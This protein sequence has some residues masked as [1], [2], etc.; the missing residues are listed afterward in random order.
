MM[1]SG[2]KLSAIFCAAG[3]FYLPV[4]S[5]DEMIVLPYGAALQS[6]I[7]SHPA[8]SDYELETGVHRGHELVLKAGDSLSGQPGAVLSGAELLV[9]WRFEDPFWIHDGPHSKAVPD[10]DP[11]AHYWEFRARWPH[12]LFVD[13]VP[14]IQKYQPAQ[15]NDETSWAYDYE[16]DR[17]YVRFDPAQ[18]KM[19]L[20]GLCR[21]G[22]RTDAPDVELRNIHCTKF[23]TVGQSAAV[24]LGEHA[25]I[26]GCIVSGCH[27]TGIRVSNHSH[28]KRSKFLWNG[29][30]G[31][32]DGGKKSVIEYCE[33]AYNGWAGFS[34][35]WSR[36][37][38][39][40][41]GSQGMVVRRNYAHHNTG[42]G[43]WF[44]I[45]SHDS[46]FEENLSEYNS[47]EGLL[48]ELSCNCEIRNNILRWNGLDP[49]G[50]LLWGVPFVIQN[51]EAA[52]VHHN[53]FE[54]APDKG[55]R[56]GGVSIINQNRPTHTEGACGT[57]VTE[58]NHIHHNVMV[59]PK[60]GYNGLQYGRFGWDT[61]EDFLAAGNLWENNTY[62]TGA[63]T[64][65]SF[66]WYAKGDSESDFLGAYHT[67]DEWQ[68]IGQDAGSKFIGKHT[69]FFNKNNPEL[70]TLIQE[71]TGLSYAELKAPFIAPIFDSNLDH[72]GD[73]MPDF[74][75]ISYDLDPMRVDSNDDMDEDGVSNLE[76]Y[77]AGTNPSSHDTDGDGMPD[78]WELQNGL[79]PVE[80]DALD[81]PDGDGLVNLEEFEAGSSPLISNPLMGH[82]P[83]E[84]LTMWLKSNGPLA[85]DETGQITPWLGWRNDGEVR[86]SRA[87]NHEAPLISEKLDNGYPMLAFGPGNLKT[88]GGLAF[89]DV[90]SEGWTL[91][92]VFKLQQE[93]GPAGTYALAGNSVWRKSGFRLTVEQ[94]FLHFYSTQQDNKFSVGSY[95][96]LLEETVVVTLIYDGLNEAGRLYID[97]EEQA[98]GAGIIPPNDIPLWIGHIGGMAYQPAYYSEVITFSRALNHLERREV[99]AMLR[100][101]YQSSGMAIADSDGDGMADWWEIE[102]GGVDEPGED[103][104]N[105]GLRNIEEFQHRTNP[106]SGD[107]DGDTLSDRWEVDNNWN[108]RRDDSTIDA[109]DDGLSSVAEEVIGS[110]PDNPDSDGDGMPDGWEVR[111]GLNLL[112]ND[113]GF[114]TDGDGLTDIQE[115]EHGTSPVLVDTDKD[116]LD[117]SWEISN[118]WDPLVN[119]STVDT[120]GDGVT[121]VKEVYYGTDFL[122]KDTDGDGFD[123][124]EELALDTDPNNPE[125]IPN[126]PPAFDAKEFHVFRASKADTG[127]GDFPATDANG[128]IVDY[129]ILN[130]VDPDQDGND[131]FRIEENRLLVNDAGD[132]NYPLGRIPVAAGAYHTLALGSGGNLAGWGRNEEGQVEVP[133]DLREPIGMAAG[134]YHSLVLQEGGG[135][136]AWGAN[137]Y[138]QADVPAGLPAVSAIATFG[139]HNLALQANGRVVGWG[140]NHYGQANVPVSSRLG[141]V[142]AIAAGAHHSMALSNDGNVVAWGANTHGQRNVP[143]NLG[144]VASIAAGY[145]H[146]LALKSEGRV[147]AW[148]QNTYGQRNV[149]AGLRGIVSISAGGYHNLALRENGTVV[150]WGRN[151]YGQA[152]VPRG[153]TGVIAIFA[154]GY[155][156]FALQSDGT[157]V[158]WG[159]DSDGQLH[160]PEGLQIDQP[161]LIRTQMLQIKV[162]AD[163]GANLVDAIITVTLVDDPHG[164]VDGDGLTHEA[165]LIAG[166]DPLFADTDRDGMM[167]GGEVGFGLD[168]LLD[169]SASD[170]DF[171]GVA[172]LDELADGSSPVEWLDS[173]DDGMHDRWELQNGLTVGRADDTADNDGDLQSNFME[174]VFGGN[175][176]DAGSAPGLQARLEDMEFPLIEFQRSRTVHRHYY[177]IFIEFLTVESTWEPLPSS[178]LT[179]THA[180]GEIDKVVLRPQIGG[181]GYYRIKV[182][183]RF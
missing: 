82:F 52:N 181:K 13:D 53:Y 100:G 162:Q 8:G 69:S 177:N 159:R 41:P 15:V 138:G 112:V 171:D 107:T 70:D 117:D 24:H 43:F 126:V 99:E 30:A 160:I 88:R 1:A 118:G 164:D 151:N 9:G 121:D 125:S 116:T 90:T 109:D 42:P 54:A 168:P 179:V 62:L 102:Y 76:E 135:V 166:T 35:N 31:L 29:L 176:M 103:P 22:I 56:G 85:M 141:E 149:P 87:Y 154:G 78:G 46:L 47:W 55:A 74:W 49:R 39:K 25:L 19:E 17:V 86:M 73:Q 44:D 37:G 75:E 156:S 180:G 144:A 71:T 145:L 113:A 137:D 133:G 175:P 77:I 157:L 4:V 147:I 110:L 12:D 134:F 84:G 161:L 27:A 2:F 28:V 95:K 18:N 11:T 36:G 148:G 158:G 163:D 89:G 132:L 66:H 91:V 155:H 150:A 173:D 146:S 139:Y 153:L 172:N 3:F 178:G 83:N 40:M 122:L 81:D 80:A 170:Y 108:P 32:H 38:A 65:G 140:R 104:D 92:M 14:I 124:G 61:Y 16:E 94:D 51:S 96:R 97:G 10:D 26:E 68:S 7:D 93:N 48:F 127:I 120:D 59:M 183:P 128:D 60:G 58:N 64:S 34:G 101:K 72:D 123:D 5:A 98:R 182:M 174:F 136:V 57:H 143:S 63:P 115:F 119:D 169:D 105:D 45:N 130:N 6:I 33:F 67:W 165:E 131:A 23:A 152:S 79:K 20:S 114:D 21:Y 129:K 167:D 50:G 106:A 142:S 111:Y